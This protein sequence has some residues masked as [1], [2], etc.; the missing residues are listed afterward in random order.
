MSDRRPIGVFDS[1]LGGLTVLVE[2]VRALPDEIFIYFGDTARVPYGARSQRIV[3]RYSA[4]VADHLLTYDIKMLVI[5]CNTA[6]AQAESTLVERLADRPVPVP[7]VG[8]IE[9]GVEALLQRTRNR[10][11]GVLGTRSTIKSGEYARR[12]LA[13]EPETQ[14]F[15]KACP[16]FVPLVE[17]GWLDKRVTRL[18]IQEYLSELQREEVDTVVL[19]CTHYPLLKGAIQSEFPEL[20]LVDSSLETARAV[21]ERLRATGLAASVAVDSAGNAAPGR[22]AVRIELTDFTDQMNDLEKLLAGIPVEK[23]EEVRL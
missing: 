2:L 9:P 15:S 19:G 23:I 17:E 11:V 18:V 13:R 1:G 10:R 8:V 4:E 5:A 7:V 3:Q 22:G 21:R 16:L 14:V 12:I 6:T 20:D